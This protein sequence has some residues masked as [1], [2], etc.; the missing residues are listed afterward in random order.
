MDISLTDV[1]TYTKAIQ[2]LNKNFI[3]TINYDLSSL[4][5]IDFDPINHKKN[6]HFSV[7]QFSKHIN[8]LFLSKSKIGTTY[9][10]I[11]R[12][13]HKSRFGRADTYSFKFNIGNKI[14]ILLSDNITFCVKRYA[15][16]KEL[17]HIYFEEVD[18]YKELFTES[19]RDV[20]EQLHVS[21]SDVNDSFKTTGLSKP[22]YIERFPLFIAMELMLPYELRESDI[23]NCFK[24]YENGKIRMY[25]IA[26]RYS[27]PEVLLH[28]YYKAGIYKKTTDIYFEI[29]NG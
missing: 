18:N 8:S 23:N 19:V 9:P 10:H 3:T 13:I 11:K 21:K 25:D 24:D 27:I 2:N 17:L 20:T 1:V 6:L 29:N 28:D 7:S 14:I 4:S 15:Y 16:L 12:Y 26:E 22:E 5:C